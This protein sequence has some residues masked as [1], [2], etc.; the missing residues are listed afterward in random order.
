MH[1]VEKLQSYFRLR[2]KKPVLEEVYLP[3]PFSRYV[4]IYNDCNVQA[5]EY[6]YVADIAEYLR[7]A[8]SKINIVQII[9]SPNS[10]HI[11][12]AHH[13]A[14]LN[15]NQLFFLIK[16]SDMV[17]SSDPLCSEACGIYD[18]PLVRLAG[19]SSPQ[20]GRP[21]F[22]KEGIH[23][24]LCTEDQP[25]FSSAEENK[26]INKILPETVARIALKHLNI[27]DP[28]PR[29]KTLYVGPLYRH[30][31]IDYIPDFKLEAN[32]S[33]NQPIT[34]RLDVETNLHQTLDMC[35][36]SNLHTVCINKEVKIEDL[37]LFKNKIKSLVVEVDLEMTVEFREMYKLGFEITLFSKDTK[38]IDDLK[39]KFIDWPVRLV[40]PKEK[41]DLP[42]T[43]PLFY[44]ST[45]LTLS[46]GK[47]FTSLS[48]REHDI[49]DNKVIDNQFF[50]DESDHF[51]IYS[52]D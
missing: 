51:L 37:S 38:K 43:K 13:V 6:T 35:S 27:K 20:T 11:P 10:E 42:E 49:D 36:H 18:K 25:S 29:Y 15:H 4:L 46:R 45:K 2:P 39:I 7:S 14:D 9:N 28:T 23:D 3:T 41:P 52:L 40:S 44:K 31:M 17:I 32:V 12:N 24:T 50:W 47:K 16:N 30:Y 34:A 8:D 21:F 1:Q 19:N 22:N 33:G 48:A 26:S 5:H